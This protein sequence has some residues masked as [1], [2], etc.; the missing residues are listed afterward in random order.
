MI[1]SELLMKAAAL[2]VQARLGDKYE[3]TGCGESDFDPAVLELDIQ[4]KNKPRA[5]AETLTV[6]YDILEKIVIEKLDLDHLQGRKPLPEQ[7]RNEV[8]EAF[9]TGFDDLFEERE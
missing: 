6:R 3:I 2:Y 9:G 8:Q 4:E 5:K 1:D 7:I